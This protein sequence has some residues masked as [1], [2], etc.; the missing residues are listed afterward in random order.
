MAKVAWYYHRKNC[1][2]C[3]K[4]DTYL[5]SRKITAETQLDARKDRFDFKAAKALL[6]EVKKLYATK[7]TKVIECDLKA[8]K[9]DDEELQAL[10]IGPSGNLRAPS[11]KNGDVML[12]GFNSDMY[13]RGLN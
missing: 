1:Q 2:T 5:E 11:I 12:V 4:A 3:L 8:D 7:G 13:D 10:L 9:L 6:K